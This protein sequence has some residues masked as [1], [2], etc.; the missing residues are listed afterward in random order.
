MADT[1]ASVKETGDGDQVL[2]AHLHSRH[3]N[4]ESPSQVAAQRQAGDTLFPSQTPLDARSVNAHSLRK[5]AVLL[6]VNVAS[7]SDPEWYV[8]EAKMGSSLVYLLNL[9]MSDPGRFQ[10]TF[11]FV[12]ERPVWSCTHPSTAIFQLSPIGAV[13]P[14]SGTGDAAAANLPHA[15]Y[16]SPPRCSLEVFT[17]RS[18]T[19]PAETDT[20][21][22][23]NADVLPPHPTARHRPAQRPQRPQPPSLD[24]YYD[25]TPG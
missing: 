3:A 10:Y 17:N 16:S 19:S 2:N 9:L 20:D 24:A 11:Y 12:A 21:G 5:L 25:T 1:G 4:E 13:H 14:V 6:H 8:I 15:P 22:D 23:A 18:T 7:L